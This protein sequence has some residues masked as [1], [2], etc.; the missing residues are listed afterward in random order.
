VAK[1]RR[2]CEESQ[3]SNGSLRKDFQVGSIPARIGRKLVRFGEG[4]DKIKKLQLATV[5]CH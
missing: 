3:V 5:S 2:L 4:S 1:V